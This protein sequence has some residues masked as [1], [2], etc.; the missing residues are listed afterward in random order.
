MGIEGLRDAE[1]AGADDGGELTEG[2][3][4]LIGVLEAALEKLVL[5]VAREGGEELE[6]ELAHGSGGS[7][8]IEMSVEGAEED[9]VREGGF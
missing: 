9:L 6:I 5:G 1:V 3:C 8:G 4:E 2:V 7:E